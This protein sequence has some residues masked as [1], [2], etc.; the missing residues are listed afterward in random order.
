MEL[1]NSQ[2][3]YLEEKIKRIEIDWESDTDKSHTINSIK[4]I[5]HLPSDAGFCSS[6]LLT[7]W[8][9]CNGGNLL[10]CQLPSIT[11]L[12]AL[13]C[14]SWPGCLSVAVTVG[15]RWWIRAMTKI[16]PAL[17]PLFVGQRRQAARS[18]LH[19]AILKC[20]GKSGCTKVIY[21][22]LQDQVLYLWFSD[23]WKYYMRS[24]I[25]YRDSN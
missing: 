18:Q 9:C 24:L 15:G 6:L 5:I 2:T 3:Y 20:E 1:A 19:S 10:T 7:V 12:S 23:M 21:F 25:Q 8:K 14:S 16:S 11:Q 4:I 22:N 13:P 17:T